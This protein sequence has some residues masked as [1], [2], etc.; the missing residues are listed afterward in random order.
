MI[1]P[2]IRDRYLRDALPI[3]LGGLAANLAR[4]VS[5]SKNPKSARAVE[6]L[7]DESRAF[8]EWSAPETPIDD[9]AQLVDIQRGL[10]HWRRIWAEAQQHPLEREELA[11]QAKAWS[12]QVL[13]MSGLIDG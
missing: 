6:G 1:K 3:R 8:I 5:F 9:A 10:T 2:E 11:K 4:I 12:D 13:A 7:L